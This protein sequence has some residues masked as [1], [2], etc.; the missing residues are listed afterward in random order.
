MLFDYV[1]CLAAIP[2]VIEDAASYL[3]KSAIFNIFAGVS[4]GTIVNFNIKEAATNA[5]RYIGSSGSSLSD[6]EYT[7]RKVEYA[8]LETNSSVAGISGMNDVWDGIDAVRTGSFPGK[9]I[10]YPHIKHMDL[11][12]LKDLKE[13]YPKIGAHLSDSGK[14]TKEAEHALLN[15]MLDL[16]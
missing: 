6:M 4:K 9:I 1:V 5:V 3:G 12:S 15:E 7:L 8:E 11:V 16:E 2:A 14:W 13:K 10:V